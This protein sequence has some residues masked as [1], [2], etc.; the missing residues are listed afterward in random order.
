LLASL[1]YESKLV[2]FSSLINCMAIL[3]TTRLVLRPFREGDIDLL[4]ELM[5]NPDF[6]RFSLGPY[7]RAQTQTV[8]DK[9]LSWNRAGLPSQFAVSL[10][11]AELKTGCKVMPVRLA[12]LLGYCGFFH[13]LVDG[14]DEI[15]I[16]YRFHPDYWNQ[17]LAT[18]AAIAVRDYAFGDLN[19]SRV[20]SLIHPDNAASRRVAEKI[21][22]H[23]ERKT[24]FKGFPA[25]VF[26]QSRVQWL[27]NPA[28]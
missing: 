12:P 8:L 3:Q 14:K 11:L 28:G 23:F 9:L 17:G 13:Q 6:M 10:R 24:V 20:I 25:Q 27:A 7:T 19:L 26:A 5:A 16:G 21:G 4:A 2:T 22:M 1:D 15:E 18:E